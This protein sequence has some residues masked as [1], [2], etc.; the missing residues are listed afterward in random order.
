MFDGTKRLLLIED[1][2][3]KNPLLEDRYKMKV[4][5]LVYK[6]SGSVPTNGGDL[7]QSKCSPFEY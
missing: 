3:N 5:I 4:N 6:F 7:I 1:Y 2:N